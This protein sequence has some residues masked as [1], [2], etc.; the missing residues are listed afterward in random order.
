MLHNLIADALKQQK[1]R[2]G[3]EDRRWA[4]PLA[5]KK[6][7]IFHLVDEK[8]VDERSLEDEQ[9]WSGRCLFKVIQLYFYVTSSSITDSFII[10][11]C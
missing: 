3:M 6:R 5:D 9:R 7:W 10:A 8:K 1:R 11:I 2:L 4:D